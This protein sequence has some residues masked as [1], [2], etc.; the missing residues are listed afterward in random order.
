MGP[1]PI[2][3]ATAILTLIMA[4]GALLLS[5]NILSDNIEKLANT[6]LKKLFN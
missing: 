5:F 3:I 6:G 1:T 4:V 2:E